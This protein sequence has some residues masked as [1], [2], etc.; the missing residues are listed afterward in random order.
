MKNRKQLRSAEGLNWNTYLINGKVYDRVKYHLE[1]PGAVFCLICETVRSFHLL[2]CSEERKYLF[3][4][5]R[6][7]DRLSV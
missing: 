2:G 4:M 5:P 6:K 7:N 1:N 3:K